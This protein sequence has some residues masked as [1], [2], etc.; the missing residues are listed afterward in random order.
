MQDYQSCCLLPETCSAAAQLT[1]TSPLPGRLTKLRAR[2]QRRIPTT[3]TQTQD[4]GIRSP[5]RL[6]STDCFPFTY[7]AVSPSAPLYKYR[8][9]RILLPLQ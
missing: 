6:C 5:R 2:Q 9:E 7:G 1:Q 8:G 4:K 3:A